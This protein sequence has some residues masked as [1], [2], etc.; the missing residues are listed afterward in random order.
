[1]AMAISCGNRGRNAIP[2]GGVRFRTVSSYAQISHL[3]EVISTYDWSASSV[4]LPA[5]V[6]R[7]VGRHESNMRVI[8]GIDAV[9]GETLNR[10]Y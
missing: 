10:L 5:E 8:A 7:G 6:M 2:D 3:D 4:M 9:G 1:M